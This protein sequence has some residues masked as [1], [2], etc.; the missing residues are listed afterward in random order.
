MHSQ[1]K[2][3]KEV[4]VGHSPYWFSDLWTNPKSRFLTDIDFYDPPAW[5]VHLH[6]STPDVSTISGHIRLDY[7]ED[8]EFL[9]E[10]QSVAKT[11]LDSSNSSSTIGGLLAKAN[12]SPTA[13][14]G[15]LLSPPS[16]SSQPPPSQSS[17]QKPTLMIPP[18]PVSTI[19]CNKALLDIHYNDFMN[20][21]P[22][23]DP[24]FWFAKVWH[25]PKCVP[26]GFI[27]VSN[28][29]FGFEDLWKCA[30]HNN[31]GCPVPHHLLKTTI[32]AKML[33]FI[34]G[35]SSAQG[36]ATRSPS[37]IS[38]FSP[39]MPSSTSPISQHSAPH[40]PSCHMFD[41]SGFPTPGR[42]FIGSLNEKP[43]DAPPSVL[44]NME[45]RSGREGLSF[46]WRR[47][48]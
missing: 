40:S 34:D 43:K 33:P 36:P 8:D 16:S 10:R 38:Q 41:H 45:T 24:P 42:H 12:A 22:P 17:S 27:S 19:G 47:Y 37:P 25:D 39:S 35:S 2:S 3:T 44:V 11:D 21:F 26:N 48:N 18:A 6:D 4:D 23:E 9:A 29:L 31:S 5:L 28:F 46:N 20:S 7:I 15:E 1:D 14:I 13:T 30:D 32:D